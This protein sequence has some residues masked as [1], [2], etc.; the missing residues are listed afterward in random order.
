MRFQTKGLDAGGRIT[1]GM[2]LTAAL[3]SVTATLSS[4]VSRPTFS[5]LDQTA[6]KKVSCH[7]IISSQRAANEPE[8]W[9]LLFSDR[10]ERSTQS[11]L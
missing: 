7:P 11:D 4:P 1:L 6:P 3:L 9:A 10:Q 2:L 8:E 5:P